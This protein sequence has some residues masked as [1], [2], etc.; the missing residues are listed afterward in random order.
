MAELSTF[1]TNHGG[2]GSYTVCGDVHRR[3]IGSR[4]LQGTDTKTD[5]FHA[6]PMDGGHGDSATTFMP[7]IQEIEGNRFANNLWITRSGYDTSTTL[8]LFYS[9]CNKSIEKPVKGGYYIKEIEKES[10]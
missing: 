2:F 8:R 5:V 9:G 4:A 6:A 3:S 10:R 7:T 1:L